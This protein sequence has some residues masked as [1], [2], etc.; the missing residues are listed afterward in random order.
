MSLGFDTGALDQALRQE[1]FDW[2]RDGTLPLDERGVGYLLGHHYAVEE[3]KQIGHEIGQFGA[4]QTSFSP[5]LDLLVIGDALDGFEIKGLRG[6]NETLSK[7]QLYEGLGQAQTLLTQP[8]GAD[9]GALKRICLACPSPERAGIESG[10]YAEFE[11]AVGETPVGLVHVGRD[12][13]RTVVCPDR[14]PFYTSDVRDT[15]VDSLR[16][17][18]G[19]VRDPERALERRAYEI[20]TDH[21]DDP[22][23]E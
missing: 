8:L 14:N 13:I 19:S 9:G 10:W 18:T 23:L 4:V 20:A 11:R 6:E 12:G 5:D 15:V 7:R 16:G 21:I 17:E 2:Y 1:V 3:G 22:L